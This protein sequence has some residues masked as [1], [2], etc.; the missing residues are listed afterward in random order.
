MA[1]F[2]NYLADQIL[3]EKFRDAAATKLG[4]V[5]VALF[6]VMPANAGTGGTELSAGNYA[7]VAV[8]TTDAAWTAPSGT[9]RLI[10]NVAI[11][12]MGTCATT[13]W[14][15]SGTPA[16]GFGLFD[17]VTAGNYLGG[18]TFASS[19]I[20]QVGDPVKFNI[21]DLNITLSAT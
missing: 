16:V 12:D 6:S 21:G 4:S 2:S 11:V 20:I 8:P 14:A 10:D 17:A 9:P 19:K 5:Y 15:P 7:R 1:G 3:N 18:N 13:D